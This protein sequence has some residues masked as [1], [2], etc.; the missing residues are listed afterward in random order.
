MEDAA[1]QIGDHLAPY[2]I[3]NMQEDFNYHAYI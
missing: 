3:V 1:T 2:D